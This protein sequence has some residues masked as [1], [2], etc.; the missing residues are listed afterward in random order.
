MKTLGEQLGDGAG[1]KLWIVGAGE[2]M[3]VIKGETAPGGTQGAEPGYSVERIEDGLGEGQRVEDF[4]AGRKLFEVD[5]AEG[6]CDFAEGMGD[7]G[8]CVAGAAEDGDAIVLSLCTGCVHAVHVAA[9]EGDDFLDLGC[10]GSIGF[11]VGFGTSRFST[12]ELRG[13]VNV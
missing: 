8:E 4:R 12:R 7:G 6:D 9:D 11:V 2:G 5:G 10:A 13:E 1:E 3:E